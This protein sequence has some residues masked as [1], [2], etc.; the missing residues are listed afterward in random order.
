[1]PNK[2]RRAADPRQASL[3]CGNIGRERIEAVLGCHDLMALGLQ[4]RDQFAEA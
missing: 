4:R 3:H 2:H 1:V